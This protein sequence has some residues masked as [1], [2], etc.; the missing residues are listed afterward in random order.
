MQQCSICGP[1]E[2]CVDAT[3]LRYP[4]CTSR[5]IDQIESWKCGSV[6][7]LDIHNKNMDNR[8]PYDRAVKLACRLFWIR[9]WSQ[10]RSQLSEVI[11]CELVLDVQRNYRGFHQGSVKLNHRKWEQKFWSQICCRLH[12]I[13]SC[14]PHLSAIQIFLERDV[15]KRVHSIRR[16]VASV[17]CD[18]SR[19]LCRVSVVSPEYKRQR[20]H[21]QAASYL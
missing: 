8:L 1:A 15:E 20:H 19:K 21:K 18:S 2:G 9:T 3:F 4:P 6:G 16:S 7:R 13:V 14:Y 10:Y 12:P 11:V 5:T 17:M